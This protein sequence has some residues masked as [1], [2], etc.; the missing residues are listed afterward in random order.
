M[1][2]FLNFFTICKIS[3]KIWSF[4]TCLISIYFVYFDQHLGAAHSYFG[5]KTIDQHLGA[6]SKTTFLLLNFAIFFLL[7]FS[8]FCVKMFENQI[9]TSVWNGQQPHT[10][11]NVQQLCVM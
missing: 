1:F 10:G 4:A 8:Y 9:L 5:C 2:N 6:N 11:L 7:F 3:T